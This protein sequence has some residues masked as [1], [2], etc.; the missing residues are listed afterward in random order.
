MEITKS[1]E[2]IANGDHNWQGLAENYFPYG[3]CD[4]IH[5][6]VQGGQVVKPRDF[7]SIIST[8]RHID[9]CRASMY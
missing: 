6:V 9:I 2:A 4:M 8:T 7:E 1:Q 3:T 5:S